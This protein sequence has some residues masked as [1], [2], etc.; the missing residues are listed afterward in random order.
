MCN[1]QCLATISVYQLCHSSIF[2]MYPCFV[3]HDK[4]HYTKCSKI[5]IY[6]NVIYLQCNI[7][8]TNYVL[9][10]GQNL[11]TTE[12]AYSRSKEDLNVTLVYIK[13]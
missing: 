10:R 13:H 6:F 5:T 1:I 3:T 11:S 2:Y 7:V 12:I 8:Y 9:K 4:A